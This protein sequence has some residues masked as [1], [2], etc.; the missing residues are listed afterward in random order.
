MQALFLLLLSIGLMVLSERNSMV[1]QWRQAAA[2]VVYPLRL[3][4]DVPIRCVNWL[5]TALS[6]QQHLLRE[7]EQLQVKL[8][9]LHAELQKMLILK[10]ENKQL[11]ALIQGDEKI[12]GKVKLARILAV[13]VSPYLQQLIIDQG[14]RAHAYVGQPVLDAYG[15]FGEIIATTAVSSRVLLATDSHFAVPVQDYRNGVRAIS[16]GSGEGQLKM[17]NVPVDADLKQGDVIVTSGLGLRFPAG[18]PVGV[19]SQVMVGKSG[20]LKQAIVTPA[21]HLDQT[22][23]VL[24]SWPINSMRRMSIQTG[25][26]AGLPNSTKGA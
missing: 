16:V 17:I 24:L 9:L 18:Y 14:T 4:V 13:Q 10:Q 22:Q 23:Q 19:V 12:A 26:H 20:F 2:V 8:A 25:L 7:N 5:S 6:S 15:V 21:A 11:A 3:I 1:Q